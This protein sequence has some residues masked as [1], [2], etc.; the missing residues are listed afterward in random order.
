MR[1]CGEVFPYPC[2]YKFMRTRSSEEKPF[3][4]IGTAQLTGGSLGEVGE[5]GLR[6][7]HPWVSISLSRCRLGPKTND[8]T[9]WS[10]VLSPVGQA[11]MT[12]FVSRSRTMSGTEHRRARGRCLINGSDYAHK[13]TISLC[14]EQK[15]A[16]CPRVNTDGVLLGTRPTGQ[17]LCRIP[18]TSLRTRVL[19][20]RGGSAGLRE[21]LSH[22]RSWISQGREEQLARTGKELGRANRAGA[23]FSERHP[24][25]L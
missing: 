1:N 7:Q 13:Q 23:E 22:H 18:E 8:L 17:R 24:R 20:G 15:Q 9:I 14:Q 5:P 6:A 10:L 12:H 25:G 3:L 2:A 11:I 16:R 19:R 21:P 4:N